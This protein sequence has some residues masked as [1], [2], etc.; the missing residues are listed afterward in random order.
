MKGIVGG[1]IILLSSKADLAVVTMANHNG[2]LGTLIFLLQ[3]LLTQCRVTFLKHLTVNL[4]SFR[5]YVC[6]C[7][8]LQRRMQLVQNWIWYLSYERSTLPK[9]KTPKQILNPTIYNIIRWFAGLLVRSGVYL[10]IG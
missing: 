10:L 3:D 5:F 7:G 8:Q 9:L 6:F 4:F 2:S 1:G